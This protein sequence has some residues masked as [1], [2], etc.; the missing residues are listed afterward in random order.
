MKGCIHEDNIEGQVGK[1]HYAICH[2]VRSNLGVEIF[3]KKK[4]HQ[5]I[6]AWK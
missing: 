2:L 5:K 6:V 3:L 1:R 4:E